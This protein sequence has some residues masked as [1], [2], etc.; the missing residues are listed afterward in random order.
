M[1]IGL[2]IVKVNVKVNGKW[3]VE[4]WGPIPRRMLMK[5]MV[6]KKKKK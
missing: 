5:L 3:T 2:Q 6:K 1:M 4:Y